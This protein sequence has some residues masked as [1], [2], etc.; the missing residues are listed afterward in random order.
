MEHNQPE[1]PALTPSPWSLPED[2]ALGGVDASTRHDGWNDQASQSGGLAAQDMSASPDGQ[3]AGPWSQAAR[4]DGWTGERMAQFCETLAET[5]LV[6]DA[7]L[8]AGKST[9][10]AYA[11]RRRVPVFAAAWEAALTIARERLADTLL[12]RSIEGTT[13]Q[14]F[15]DGELVGEK[16]VI[17]NRLGLAILRR[18][19]QL[20]AGQVPGAPVTAKSR[21]APGKLID[22]D[23]ALSALRSSEP[24]A[25]AEALAMLQGDKAH[26]AHDPPI[27][28]PSD[29][30]RD[31]GDGGEE[32][33]DDGPI[34]IWCEEG[35]WFTDFAPPPAY[36]DYEKGKWGDYG[37]KRTC[38]VEESRLLDADKEAQNAGDR[39]EDE[40]QR[41]AYFAELKADLEE[42]RADRNGTESP[43]T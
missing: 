42:N 24:D 36:N 32:F 28:P 33:E 19:D 2:P 22:W 41:E 17:D 8:A 21:P 26:E 37:Y 12:A 34:R 14:Y 20:S 13:E 29:E 43:A 5:G 30:L 31:P 15:K 10:T 16:R 25:V 9:N 39:A 35:V 7:C 38:S 6:V 40:A 11:L 4:H 18:L 27:Q 3:C 1:P 23:L